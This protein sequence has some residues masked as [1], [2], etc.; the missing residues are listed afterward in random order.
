MIELESRVL[1]KRVSVTC[2]FCFDK[3]IIM[4]NKID[5]KAYI[6]GVQIKNAMPYLSKADAKH[7]EEGECLSCQKKPIHLKTN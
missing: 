1:D 4:V 7:L 2:R 5:Y 6:A 3:A